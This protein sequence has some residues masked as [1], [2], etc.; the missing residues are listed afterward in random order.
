MTEISKTTD[1]EMRA[2][3]ADEVDAVGGGM[4]AFALGAII[5]AVAFTNSPSED[6]NH[7]G[8]RPDG[9]GWRA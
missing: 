7:R 6:Q 4:L 9:I 3:S 8:A 1:T 2:L 5:I